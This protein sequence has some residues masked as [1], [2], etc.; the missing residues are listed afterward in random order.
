[1][2]HIKAF[3]DEILNERQI[4]IF[5][6]LITGASYSMN[7]LA[8]KFNVSRVTMYSDIEKISRIGIVRRRGH[9][10]ATIKP[11]PL[12]RTPIGQRLQL[13]KDLK[14]TMAEAIVDKYIDPG[15]RI[16]L[17]CGTSSLAVAEKIIE[18]QLTG[19]TILTLNPLILER[20]IFQPGDYD[21]IS[22]GGILKQN[23]LAMYG[24]MTERNLEELGEFDVV[25]MG[26][27][28]VH[29][30]GSLALSTSLEVQ[31]K[32]IMVSKGKVLIVPADEG[33]ICRNVGE[34][35]TSIRDIEKQGKLVKVV[36]GYREPQSEEF[37]RSI[38]VLEENLGKKYLHLVPLKI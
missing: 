37:S 13:N 2:E 12:D 6:E 30:D 27:D 20:F 31:Q 18:S 14:E 19:I 10:S 26:V 33:K 9:V 35:I 38:Q 34:V 1:M 4:A 28:A 24:P 16:L 29:D 7:E 25:V 5:S 11:D 3:E 22:L 8:Q 17:D 23:T 32:G 15:S 36:I 21:I